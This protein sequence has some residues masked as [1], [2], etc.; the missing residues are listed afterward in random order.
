VRIT[1][2]GNLAL[3][4]LYTKLKRE[5]KER[6]L[7][8]L[9]NAHLTRYQEKGAHLIVV[10]FKTKGGGDEHHHDVIG[11]L[12]DLAVRFQSILNQGRLQ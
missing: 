4:P 6:K 5:L 9:L 7:E 1:H 11:K 8:G 12:V 10:P 3:I 2:T